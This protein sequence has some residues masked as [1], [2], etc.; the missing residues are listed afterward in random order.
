MTTWLTELGACW[1]A[2]FWGFSSVPGAAEGSL[3][4]NTSPSE[5]IRKNHQRGAQAVKGPEK[6]GRY[7]GKRHRLPDEARFREG[8]ERE[9]RTTSGQERRLFH[10]E[11]SLDKKDRAVRTK[12]K[13]DLLKKEKDFEA[14]L[15]RTFEGK[16]AEA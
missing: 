15:R 4:N 12:G 14:V 1:Q 11:E 3:K 10:K 8:D 2:F 6:R 13:K 9:K 5:T 16:A 7:P